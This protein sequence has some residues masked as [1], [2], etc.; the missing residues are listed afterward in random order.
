MKA[1]LIALVA[2]AVLGGCAGMQQG[3]VFDTTEAANARAAAK[4]EA[5]TLRH[6]TFCH[7]IGYGS[8]TPE[9]PECMLAL[10][11]A[12]SSRQGGSR[13]NSFVSYRRRSGHSRCDQKKTRRS[14]SSVLR[15]ES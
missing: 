8:G 15:A 13:V 10:E 6:G 2:V 14:G 11:M 5:R 3:T 1:L 12:W 4:A 9:Y 7:S